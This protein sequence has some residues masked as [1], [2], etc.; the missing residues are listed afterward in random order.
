MRIRTFLSLNA[1]VGLA[2]GIILL[3]VPGYLL[4]LNGIHADAAAIMI[5]RLFGAEFIGF[6][7]VTWRERNDEGA[8]GQRLVVIGHAVS[9]SLGFIITLISRLSGLGNDLFWGIVGA[10]L[11]FAL[12]YVYFYTRMTERGSS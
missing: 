12:G 1:V 11:L 4:D 10:Y 9:E 8:P 2:F 7:I 6:N 3:F 5:A